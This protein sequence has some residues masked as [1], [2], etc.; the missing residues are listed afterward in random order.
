MTKNEQLNKITSEYLSAFLG[1]AIHKIGNFSEAEELAQEIACQCVIAVRRGIPEEKFDAYLWSVAHNTFKRWCGRKKALPLDGDTD[2]LS[3]IASRDLPAIER[4]I[5]REEADSVRLALS[6]LSSDY[7]KT[8]VSVYYDELSIRDTAARLSLTEGMVKFYLRAGKRKL[9]EVLDMNQIGETSFRPSDLTIY[10]SGIDLSR[11]NVWEL[12]KRKLP[13]QIAILCHDAPKTESELS[14]EIGV[15]AVYLEEEIE[16]LLNAGVLIRPSR[17]KLRTNFHILKEN[18]AAQIKAQFERLVGAYA[19]DA[20]QT[21]EKHLAELKK[22]DIFK[23]DATPNQWAWFFA[24]QIPDFDYE[25]HTL[26]DEDFPQI[27]SCGSRSF[28]F[29]QMAENSIWGRGVTPVF[30]ENCTVWPVDILAFGAF[31]CQTELNDPR[32]AQALYDLYRATVREEDKPLYAELIEQGYAVKRG[33]SLYCNVAVHTEKS[34][35][36]LA[37]INAELSERL[38]PLCGEIRENVSRI[39]KATLPE[40]LGAYTEGFTE[41]WLSLYAG[42]SLLE[43]LYRRGFLQIPEKDD[44]TP[45]ACRIDELP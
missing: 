20:V 17:N 32:K 39:V 37:K 18:A 34:R 25:G 9:K 21:Y 40:Q 2:C 36:L 1:F 16:I 43:A 11:V 44:P 19:D 22:C 38:R 26:K 8:L 41:T 29:G 33:E 30:L 13:C 31:H 15:P 42:T 28:V 10:K 3:N 5:E 24:E 27:L 14:V 23:F 4:I 35:A 12:F 7:R 6:R 45:L